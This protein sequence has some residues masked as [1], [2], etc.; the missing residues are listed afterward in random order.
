LD[1]AKEKMVRLRDRTGEYANVPTTLYTK[2]N[3]D[4]VSLIIYGLNPGEVDDQTANGY[5]STAWS[6]LLD[7]KI[8]SLYRAGT[9]PD[10][11]QF[12]PIWQVFLDSS[13]GLLL[14]D[15]GY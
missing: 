6:S 3:T 5:T 11:R 2:F 13:N 1:E 8:N 10:N 7:T 15:Y 14:N 9:N 4:N 12:W